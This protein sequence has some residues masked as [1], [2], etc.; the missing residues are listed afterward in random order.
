MTE[1]RTCTRCGGEF[2]VNVHQ[3]TICGH[4]ECDQRN[5]ARRLEQN[6]ALTAMF[7]RTAHPQWIK[8]TAHGLQEVSDL[9]AKGTA[10]GLNGE[11]RSPQEEAFFMTFC[12]L[13]D[14]REYCNRTR[15][16]R[17]HGWLFRLKQRLKIWLLNHLE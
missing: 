7:T 14:Y 10:E 3:V 4:C 8:L 15:D 11:R 13:W 9:Y 1:A 2:D 6:L 12:R 17:H 5:Q 16:G